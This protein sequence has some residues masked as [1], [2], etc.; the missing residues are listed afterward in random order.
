[1][2]HREEHLTVAER[3]LLEYQRNREEQIKYLKNHPEE[4][5]DESIYILTILTDVKIGWVVGRALHNAGIV[6]VRDLISSN[7]YDLLR[8]PK[9]G[10][11][12]VDNLAKAIAECNLDGSI[13]NEVP[14]AYRDKEIL[15]R[16][17]TP[18]KPKY[19]LTCVPSEDGTD[20][21]IP[22]IT[23]EGIRMSMSEFEDIK[24]RLEKT[25]GKTIFMQIITNELLGCSYHTAKRDNVE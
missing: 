1:M 11:V 3:E 2:D 15:K 17:K 16:H 21:I 23:F 20:S 4:L 22:T 18:S 5:L 12:T 19:S 24:A 25:T 10:K 7:K 9:I 6:D 8:I 13:F 14:K